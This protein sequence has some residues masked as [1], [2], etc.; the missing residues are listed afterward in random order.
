[1]KTFKSFKQRWRTLMD[2]TQKKISRGA[3]NISKMISWAKRDN[4]RRKDRHDKRSPK[5]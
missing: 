4:W 5:E 1:M 3:Y 2:S